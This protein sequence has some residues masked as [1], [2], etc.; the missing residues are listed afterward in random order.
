MS[1]CPQCSAVDPIED[2]GAVLL[3]A[4]RN[5]VSERI[6]GFLDA[7]NIE[8]ETSPGLL[9]APYA[10]KESLLALLHA[11]RDGLPGSLWNEV[12]FGVQGRYARSYGRPSAHSTLSQFLALIESHDLVTIIREARFASHMQPIVDVRTRGTYGYEFLLRPGEPDRPFK[13]FELFRVA[14][15]TGLHSFLDRQAR[16]SAIE[17]SAQHLPNGIKRFINFLPSSIYNPNYCLSHTFA[18][19]DRLRLDPADFVFE[20]VETERIADVDHLLSIFQVYK[21][22]GMK[23]ALDDVGSGFA[24]VDVLEKLQPD[25]VKIDRGLIDRCDADAEKQR[26]IERIVTAARGFGASVLGEGIERMEE[27]RYLESLGVDYAQGYLFA[28]PEPLPQRVDW[29]AASWT[30]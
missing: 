17:T 20:V 28:K 3:H 8:T 30:A 21:K 7:R 19:I 2:A 18:A 14:Q 5:D 27:F 25:V 11:L 12:R 29:S 10:T 26:N 24:T 23:V 4:D 22:E 16:I 9:I 13:P 15:E 1:S 6:Q